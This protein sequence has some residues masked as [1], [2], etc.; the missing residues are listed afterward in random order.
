MVLAA[1]SCAAQNSGPQEAR[2]HV[3]PRTVA[4]RAATAP[5]IRLDIHLVLIPVTVTDPLGAP[6]AGLPS[7]TFRLFDNG[8]EQQVRYFASDEAP[9]SLGI[10]FD[11]SRSMTGKLDRSREAVSRVFQ[12]SMPG[13][14][15]FVVEFN[16]APRLLS[17]FS[18]R[19]DGIESAL[20]AIQPRNW[21]AL[22]DAVYFSIHQMRRAHNPRRALLILSDG[23]D[24]YSRY[25]EREMRSLVRETGVCIYAISLGGGLV[26]HNVRLLRDLAHE[27]GG[28]VCEVRKMEELSDAVWKIGAAM[29]HQYVLGFSPSDRAGDGLYR[30]IEVRLDQPPGAPRLHATWRSGYYPPAR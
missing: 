3:T 28:L 20:A 7:G 30:K 25:T 1:A 4:R 8:V 21:T 12:T 15:F 27:T 11:A 22:L 6:V 23:G 13:D 26:R 24:N 29:R 18:S 17:A 5:S 2:I 14:E 9:V 16:D 19:T 10:V